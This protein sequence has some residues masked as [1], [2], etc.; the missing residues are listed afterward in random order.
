MESSIIQELEEEFLFFDSITIEDECLSYVYEPDDK[1]LVFTYDEANKHFIGKQ[2]NSNYQN[3]SNVIEFFPYFLEECLKLEELD[4]P[5]L[6]KHFSSLGKKIKA[7]DYF[8]ERIF[9]IKLLIFDD[10]RAKK[11]LLRRKS[12]SL[13]ALTQQEVYNSKNIDAFRIVKL[14]DDFTGL[15][16]KFNLV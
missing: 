14:Y 4:L 1:K 9:I 11:E 5:T 2:Y 16:A 13:P 8:D 12:L 7:K 6:R 3:L 10:S 15:H